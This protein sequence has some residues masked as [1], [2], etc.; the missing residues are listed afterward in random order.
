MKGKVIAVSGGSSGIGLALSKSLVQKG[1]KISICDV[2][3]ANLDN[4]TK[5]MNSNDVLAIKC[6]VRNSSE[7]RSWIDATIDKFGRLD[8]AAN[9]A[10][11]IGKKPGVAWVEEQDEDD[12]SRILGVN[13][14]GVMLCMKEEI[15]VMKEGSSIVNAS[16]TAGV[17]GFPGHAAYAVSKH[18]VT[19]LTRTS[20]VDCARK[21]IR[22]NAVAPGVIETPMVAELSV[23]REEDA[24]AITKS[25]PMKR[26]GRPDEVA[27]VIA[28]LL[29]D[30]ASFV[31]GSIYAVDGGWTAT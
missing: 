24:D 14:T 2:V 25:K 16:S 31:T 22:V 23:G 8:G 17:R 1:A 11:I 27:N 7:V 20:A 26:A 4:A 19:G 6:D 30:E 29:S 13:L 9:L 21:G 18:G 12:W 28:F 10:G 15:R 5:E 3:Q